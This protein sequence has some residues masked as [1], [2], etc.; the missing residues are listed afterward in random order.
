[1]GYSC[2]YSG[3]LM[4]DCLVPQVREDDLQIIAD[5]VREHYDLGRVDSPE[6]MAGAHQFRHRKM[7]V[8]TEKGRFL[9]KTYRNDIQVLDAL[10]FQHRLSDHLH[11]NGLPVAHIE[12]ARDGR[13]LVEFD[14]WALELQLY[15][16]ATSMGISKDTLMSS[17][18]ALGRFHRVCEGFP[19]PPRDTRMWRFSEVPRES[20]QRLYQRARGEGDPERIDKYCNEIALFLQSATQALSIEKRSEFQTGL[21]HGDW[22]GGNLLYR[23]TE[24]AAIV[25]LEFAG[26]GCYLEDLAYAISNLCVRS[27]TEPEQLA[28]RTNIVLDHYQ[29]NRKLSYAELFALYYA[30]G[31][32]H[33]ATVAYQTRQT[34]PGDRI[35]GY[36]TSEWMERLAIQC[37]WLANE[38]HRT[39]FGFR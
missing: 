21:I 13:S 29:L 38:G 1:M 24:L 5:V 9:A 36:T 23:G 37:R 10:R 30:V 28:L 32:K 3:H 18:D 25:D 8:S 11:E 27:T 12:R 26:D 4:G 17:S 15:V 16:D 39:R 31:I 33:V 22:H 20:F 34:K 14:D 19:V 7:I 35:A 2:V 6:L